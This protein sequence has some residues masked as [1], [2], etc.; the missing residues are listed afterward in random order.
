MAIILRLQVSNSYNFNG[1]TSTYHGNASIE[2]YGRCRPTLLI[3]L[4]PLLITSRFCTIY[5]PLSSLIFAMADM[6]SLLATSTKNPFAN[7]S[8]TTLLDSN[9]HN[10]STH[11]LVRCPPMQCEPRLILVDCLLASLCI[12]LPLST[13]SHTFSQ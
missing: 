8:R 6:A 13:V 4:L 2:Q 11:W 3:I 9:Q 12:L 1:H 5:A 10:L 7:C